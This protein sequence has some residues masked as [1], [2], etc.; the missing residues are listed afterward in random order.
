MLTVLRVVYRFV[1]VLLSDFHV[2]IIYVAFFMPE[3][4][5]YKVPDD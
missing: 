3:M 2:T 5:I 1:F 4:K